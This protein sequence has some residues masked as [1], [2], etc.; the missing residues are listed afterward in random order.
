MVISGARIVQ[1]LLQAGFKVTAGKHKCLEVS[2]VQD[3]D[4]C[5][6]DVSPT[7]QVWWTR[8]RPRALSTLQPPW[9]C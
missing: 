8:S 5:C 7:E 3:A 4:E 6:E 1:K 9:S 2:G